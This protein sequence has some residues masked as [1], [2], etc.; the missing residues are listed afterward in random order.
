MHT[1]THAPGY[2]QGDQVLV[3]AHQDAAEHVH[4]PFVALQAPSPC[5]AGQ[6]VALEARTARLAAKQVSKWKSMPPTPPGTASTPLFHR[7]VQ[8][9]SPAHALAEAHP[10]LWQQCPGMLGGHADIS[11]H[12]FPPTWLIR[13]HAHAH[14][15]ACMCAHVCVCVFYARKYAC[16]YLCTCV[17]V[18]VCV[19]TCVYVYAHACTNGS[20]MLMGA[21][22]SQLWSRACPCA[23]GTPLRRAT[24]PTHHHSPTRC[25]AP[26]ASPTCATGPSTMGP[27]G[28]TA[29]QQPGSIT[30]MRSS[31]KDG[32]T[33]GNSYCRA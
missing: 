32:Q 9:C 21:W 23:G 2:V 4:H 29:A 1:H 27:P 17:H 10:S 5:A 6:V 16:A 8:A 25:P 12:T 26:R 24:G 3:H 18:H 28:V 15:R 33:E 7:T 19:R 31:K 14:A 20:L 13:S 22:H 11:T 30:R